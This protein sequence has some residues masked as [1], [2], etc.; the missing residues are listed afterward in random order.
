ME[1]PRVKRG[2]TC[3]QIH[4]GID[5]SAICKCWVSECLGAGCSTWQVSS[6]LSVIQC[7]KHR[8]GHCTCLNPRTGDGAPTEDGIHGDRWNG[9]P[10]QRASS[11]A[12]HRPDA[13]L[14]TQQAHLQQGPAGEAY[15]EFPAEPAASGRHGS[16]V[17][18]LWQLCC[19][20][21]LTNRACTGARP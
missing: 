17:P 2:I 7:T 8:C 1:I 6:H 10:A 9:R 15:E 5:A 3:C 14:R 12:R 20:S 11:A 13:S 4:T 18:H 19:S 21:A 16:G